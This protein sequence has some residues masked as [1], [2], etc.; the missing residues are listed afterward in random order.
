MF[1]LAASVDWLGYPYLLDIPYDEEEKEKYIHAHDDDC[2]DIVGVSAKQFR[3]EKPRYG[4][5]NRQQNKG[6]IFLVIDKRA[7]FFFEDY[8]I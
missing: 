1:R 2:R 5:R 7:D 3:A 8:Q 4:K 6:K